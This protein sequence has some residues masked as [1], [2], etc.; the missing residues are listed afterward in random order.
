MVFGH[1][2]DSNIHVE[3]AL[4]GADEEARKGIQAV[5]YDMVSSFKGSVSAEHGIGQIKRPYLA[6]SRS[7]AELTLMRQIKATLDPLG[8]LNPGRVL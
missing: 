8:I 1:V 7:E 2:A 3:V 5:V 6:R 4:E